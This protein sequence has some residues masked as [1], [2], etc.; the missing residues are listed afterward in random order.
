[1]RE[2]ARGVVGGVMIDIH[3]FVIPNW[4]N[5]LFIGAVALAAL[6]GSWRERS[7]AGVW[8]ATIVFNVIGR[9]LSGGPLL[10]SATATLL[11][12]VVEDLAILAVCLACV[13]RCQRWWVLWA[14]SAFVVILAIDLVT[15]LVPGVTM[16]A[17]LSANLVFNYLFGAAVIW[18]SLASE[19]PQARLAA[20]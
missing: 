11:C 19:R 1:M 18:G 15:W 12:F 4:I 20:A 9:K 17:N 10:G 7:I 8:L 16:W 14:T 5:H 2:A 13:L 3:L 6:R